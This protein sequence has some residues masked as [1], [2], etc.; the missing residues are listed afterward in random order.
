[1]S[2]CHARGIHLGPGEGLTIRNPVGGRLTFKVQSDGTGGALTA[3]ESVAAPGEGPP[4]HV[5]PELDEALYVL[6]GIFRI[7]LDGDVLDAPAGAFTWI[8]RGLPH[9][10]QNV[11]DGPGRFLALVL[12]A[13]LERFFQAFAD[14][15]AGSSV[16]EAFRTLG[17]EGGIEVVGPPLAQSHP[18]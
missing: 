13:G 12:P 9:T 11:G 17:P 8:P 4:M 3:I 1:M 10:W 6:E 16:P 7:A 15:P 5:H 18:G 2:E 14:L